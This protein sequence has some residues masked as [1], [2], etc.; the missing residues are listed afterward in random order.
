MGFPLFLYHQDQLKL[1]LQG[2]SG[3][4][5]SLQK[6]QQQLRLIFLRIKIWTWDWKRLTVISN[7]RK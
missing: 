7:K 1:H 4:P 2:E 5:I 3:F 6:Q